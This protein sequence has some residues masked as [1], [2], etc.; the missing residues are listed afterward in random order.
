M[1]PEP[2]VPPCVFFCCSSSPRSSGGGGSVWPVD[3]VAPPMELKIPSDPS[4]PY[5]RLLTRDYKN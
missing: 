3:T 1:Q 5:T 4:V 2:W